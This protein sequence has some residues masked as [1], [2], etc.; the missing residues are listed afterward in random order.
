MLDIT[1]YKNPKTF[2]LTSQP[3]IAHEVLLTLAKLVF[4]IET[5][6]SNLGLA[7]SCARNLN[8]STTVIEEITK[9]LPIRLQWPPSRT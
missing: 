6:S 9:A 8:Y 2:A 4:V 1:T 5:L 3:R 7:R